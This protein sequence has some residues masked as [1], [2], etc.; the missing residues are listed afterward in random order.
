ML[1]P[2]TSPIIRFKDSFEPKTEYRLS[3]VTLDIPDER[4][5]VLRAKTHG[6][7]GASAWVRAWISNEAQG[8]L[9]E[10]EDGNVNAGDEVE[11]RL[12]LDRDATPELACIRIESEQFATKHTLH[13][14]LTTGRTDH[15]AT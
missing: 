10:V 14:E 3:E 9:A 6:P 7:C 13:V 2:T 5:A 12:C 15:D 8:T 4:T 11:L 1:T